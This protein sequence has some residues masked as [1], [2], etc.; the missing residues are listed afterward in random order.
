[1]NQNSSDSGIN[2]NSNKY[3]KSLNDEKDT[4]EDI[5]KNV[6]QLVKFCMRKNDQFGT[7]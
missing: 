7:V 4:V 3:P 1:M 2:F 5:A 6:Q